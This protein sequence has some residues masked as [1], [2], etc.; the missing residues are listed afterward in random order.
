MRTCETGG[1]GTTFQLG[2]HG[3]EDRDRRHA[4]GSAMDHRHR[5]LNRFA[6]L[7]GCWTGFLDGQLH[8]TRIQRPRG[9]VVGSIRVG[10]RRGHRNFIDQG[11]LGKLV[12]QTLH[13][14]GHDTTGW[15]TQG[16][17]QIS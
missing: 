13:G 7:G 1:K 16:L 2:R 10:E 3:V 9:R 5:I 15:K 6:G 14:V 12:E 11:P 17:A 8:R 4:T